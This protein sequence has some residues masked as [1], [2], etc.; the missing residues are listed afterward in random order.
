[1]K[2]H[3]LF[4]LPIIVGILFLGPGCDSRTMG[5]I[6]DGGVQR[7]ARLQDGS[8]GPDPDGHTPDAST[9]ELYGQVLL[10]HHDDI[11][12][13]GN[14][15]LSLHA[16][17]YTRPYEPPEVQGFELMETRQTPNGVS[18]DIYF[19]S[20]MN[21]DPPPPP[22]DPPPQ[23]NGGTI[24]AGPG[25]NTDEVLTVRFQGGEYT[26]D[27]RGGPQNPLPN[28]LRPGPQQ[29]FFDGEGSAAV[30]WF[31][32]DLELPAP[33][34]IISPN[35]DGD[36]IDPGQDGN[37]VISWQSAGAEETVL[38]INSNMDWDDSVFACHPNP[39]TDRVLIPM[40]WIMDWTWGYSEVMVALRNKLRTYVPNAD[41]VFT[42]QGS[43]QFFAHFQIWYP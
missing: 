28:W 22:P 27:T 24:S 35:T 17:F 7:D 36:P 15:W 32:R 13:Y 12:S 11:S 39:G 1:M 30:E 19:R 43:T 21:P 25:T 41:I 38:Y 20:G 14:E 34:T 33:P 6:G 37:Y 29:I 23:R 42:T 4:H 5:V 8:N 31:S 2:T 18:C 40:M 10:Y 26:I 3:P 16:A 9:A